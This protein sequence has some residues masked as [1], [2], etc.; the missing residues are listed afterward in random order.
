MSL[1]AILVIGGIFLA[2][3][4][5]TR[6]TDRKGWTRFYKVNAWKGAVTFGSGYDQY[7]R[8]NY[9]AAEEYKREI[10][11]EED[12]EGRKKDDETDLPQ[13]AVR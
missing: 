13:R 3:W 12:G 2:L 10:H 7:F 5:L 8:P 6:W 1:P 9:K 4:L 11:D